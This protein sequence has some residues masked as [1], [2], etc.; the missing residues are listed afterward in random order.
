MNFYF[1]QVFP[2][3]ITRNKEYRAV[4]VQNFLKNAEEYCGFK[5]L[6]YQVWGEQMRKIVE[7][8]RK[9]YPRTSSLIL[10][11]Y[12]DPISWFVSSKP[13]M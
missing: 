9:L 7:T 6:S 2:H 11:T 13:N 10:F 3:N 8:C 12:R 1:A 4:A 5:V